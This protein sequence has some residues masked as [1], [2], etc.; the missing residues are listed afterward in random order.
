M[1][2]RPATF[3]RPRPLV[4][5]DDGLGFDAGQAEQG[6][7][8]GELVGFLA[9]DDAGGAVGEEALGQHPAARAGVARGQ[10]IAEAGG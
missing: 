9:V 10:Q 5:A 8:G 6:G 3:H 4:R 2:L 1:K 7:G